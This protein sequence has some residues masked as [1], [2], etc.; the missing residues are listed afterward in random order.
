MTS[1]NKRAELQA[2]EALAENLY[3]A[4]RERRMALAHLPIEEKIR[5]IV[6]LQKWAYDIRT[7]VGAPARKPWGIPE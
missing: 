2:L 5:I 4:K 7:S 1:D 3:R 6:E